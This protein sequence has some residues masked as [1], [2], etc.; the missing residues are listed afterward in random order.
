MRQSYRSLTPEFRHHFD[1]LDLFPTNPRYIVHMA[2][3]YGGISGGVLTDLK[4]GA[5]VADKAALGLV[6]M[7]RWSDLAKPGSR[8]ALDAYLQRLGIEHLD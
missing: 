7:I 5:A 2:E 4:A 3:H 1:R 8:E 6:S